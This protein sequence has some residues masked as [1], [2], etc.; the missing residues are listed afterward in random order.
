MCAVSFS[1]VKS[2]YP[3][4]YSTKFI[5]T[6][7]SYLMTASLMWTV[8]IAL[9]VTVLGNGYLWAYVW[10][11]S[12]QFILG[13]ACYYAAEFVVVRW[14][15]L[16]RALTEKNGYLKLK[17][18]RVFRFVLVV[19]DLMYLPLALFFGL[20]RMLFWNLFCIVSYVRPDIN[21]YPRGLESYDM[22]HLTF[23]ATVRLFVEREA[24][25][26]RMHRQAEQ[27]EHSTG[28]NGERPKAMHMED[29]NG[30]DAL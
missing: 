28:G 14:L 4:W 2:E 6:L 8:Q 15:I 19:S 3:V 9:W 30:D 18:L 11:N 27:Q 22:G 10:E 12:W 13:Y 29:D 23:V 17:R 24:E 1:Y 16:G 25:F 21:V 20:F 26:P 7:A 5:S